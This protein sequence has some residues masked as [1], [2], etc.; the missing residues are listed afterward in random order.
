M[1]FIKDM[2]SSPKP[3]PA[4]NYGQLSQDQSALDEKSMRL[5]TA[6][7]RPDLVT[8]YSTTTFRETGPD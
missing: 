1:G 4:I 8:P 6:L 3:P 5:Q 2:F 7:S